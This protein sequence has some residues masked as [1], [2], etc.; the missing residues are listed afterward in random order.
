MASL[1]S[2][3][4]AGEIPAHKIAETDQY[5]AFLDVFPVAPGHTLVI[6]KQEIDYLF[7]MDEAL[8]TGLMQ[9]ARQLAP[10]L[11]RAVP[12]QRIGVS[13]IGLEVPHAHV[14][15]IPLNSMADMDFSKK[16]KLSADEL[17]DTAARIRAEL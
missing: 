14:H 16:L 9:F 7:D 6:P 5:L 3:I 4:V 1:F 13:V 10:A 11:Q 17:A 15:L 12:C 2:K 8:Y